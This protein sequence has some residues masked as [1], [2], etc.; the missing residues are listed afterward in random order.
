M[1]TDSAISLHSFR[2]RF[3]ET[4][5]MGIVHHANYLAYFEMG[6]VEWL[7]ERGITYAA[8]AATGL[9]L[10]VAEVSLKYRAPAKF[11]NHL[12]LETRLAEV[13]THSLRFDYRLLKEDKVLTDGAT[14]LACVDD[15]GKLSRL[16]P[17]MADTF[18]KALGIALPMGRRT[19]A[20]NPSPNT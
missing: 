2:V 15:A 17:E 12:T 4:D 5:L 11:D 20:T 1:S 9:H 18:G 19:E 8:W 7:R 13:R 3:C 14:R 10:A 6:R 16:S